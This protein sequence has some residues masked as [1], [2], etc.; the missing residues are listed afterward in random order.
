MKKIFP[1]ALSL[2][3]AG[4]L[5]A[6]VTSASSANVIGALRVDSSE[7]QTVVAV[8]WVA[9]GLAN[10]DIRVTDIVKTTTLAVGDQLFAYEDGAYKCWVLDDSK[11]WQP[12]QVVKAGS[13][14]PV[15]GVGAANKVLKRGCAVVLVRTKPTSPGYFFVLG[16]VSSASSNVV[17]TLPASEASLLAPPSAVATDLNDSSAVVWGLGS[18]DHA[19]DRVIFKNASGAMCT[20]KRKDGAWKLFDTA[21]RQWTTDGVVIPAGQGA[22]YQNRS[23]EAVTVTWK[24]AP[25]S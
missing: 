4:A 11:V 17:Q 5:S 19:D 2:L 14:L 1:F 10:G 16:Q 24:N 8:P 23:A 22:W 20:A 12:S 15:A 13:F 21:K 7:K 9:S 25:H 18:G 6:A 3:S